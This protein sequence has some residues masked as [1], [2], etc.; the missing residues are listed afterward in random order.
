MTGSLI[1]YVTDGIVCV[2]Y[3]LYDGRYNCLCD[4]RHCLCDVLIVSVTGDTLCVTYCRC[5]GRHSVCDVLSL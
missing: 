2:T 3:C 5:D 1:V 4:G